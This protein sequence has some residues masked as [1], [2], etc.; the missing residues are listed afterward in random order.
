MRCLLIATLVAAIVEPATAATWFPLPYTPPPP[1][2]AHTAVLDDQ[3]G[4]I[5][6]FGG[7]HTTGPHADTWI[8]PGGAL[9][10]WLPLTPSVTP[11]GRFDHVAIYDA[12]GDRMII[13]GGQDLV[14]VLSD[15]WALDLANPTGWV[16]LSPTGTAPSGRV[17]HTAVY[18]PIGNRIIVHG[19]MDGFVLKDDLWALDLSGTPSWQ[20][21]TPAGPAP[22]ARR[23]AVA[24]Y[25]PVRHRMLLHGGNPGSV[26]LL[27]DVWALD[28]AGTPSWSELTATNAAP[29]GTITHSGAYDEARDR[30]VLFAGDY[31]NEVWALTLGASMEWQQLLPGGPPPPGRVD[32]TLVYDPAEDRMVTFG[33]T[34]GLV[35]LDD[36][37]FLELATASAVADRV[38]R[39]S[40]VEVYPNPASSFVRLRLPAT[41]SPGASDVTLYDARGRVVRKLGSSGRSI[42]FDTRDA[43]GAAL[44]AGVYFARVENASGRYTARIVVVR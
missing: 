23:D 42:E 26:P 15:V 18:D 8:L 28:L 35:I 34:N 22:H 16:Q 27:N 39:V 20:Q 38:P 14:G 9:P 1:R 33:G 21:L 19:G 13:F 4:H 40:A 37:W 7:V 25:D 17:S 6:M 24:I 43:A 30:L 41:A 44:P 2:L 10:T 31:N 3:R 12:A 36:T 11:P 32:P 29:P 5:V